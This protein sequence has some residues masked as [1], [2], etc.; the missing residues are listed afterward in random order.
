[1]EMQEELHPQLH[2]EPTWAEVVAGLLGKWST[3]LPIQDA[4]LTAKGIETKGYNGIIADASFRSAIDGVTDHEFAEVIQN[5]MGY[6]ELPEAIRVMAALSTV[7]SV[8]GYDI[9]AG[10]TKL[11][12]R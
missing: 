2:R 12:G 9:V 5:R 6:A 3:L 4:V 1:M 11:L 10:A 7:T 8:L